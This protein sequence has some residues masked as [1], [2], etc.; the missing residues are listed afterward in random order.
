VFLLPGK[1][2]RRPMRPEASSGRLW[3]FDGTGVFLLSLMLG[4]IVYEHILS[5]IDT[6]YT[7]DL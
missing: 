3:A 5:V 6:L 7:I 4:G 1:F 2:K